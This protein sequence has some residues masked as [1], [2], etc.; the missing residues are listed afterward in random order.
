MLNQFRA[1][2]WPHIEYCHGV[3]MHA[4]PAQL[5]RLDKVQ[6]SFLRALGL[7]DAEA[8]VRYN[9]APPN[10]RRAIGILGF[11]HKRTLCLCH[12]GVVELL[13]YRPL[14]QR[15]WHNK[16]LESCWDSVCAHPRLFKSSLWAHVLMYNRMPQEF[17]DIPDV[18][19]FQRTLNTIA[20]CR[21]DVGDPD[22]RASFQS[23]RDIINVLH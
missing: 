7:T 18:S 5:A 9:F 11:V 14:D 2:I 1:H 16:E 17:V 15:V 23:C 13:P 22:W 4:P 12:P 10:V 8:F 21:A 20:K 3:L 19:S 6:A